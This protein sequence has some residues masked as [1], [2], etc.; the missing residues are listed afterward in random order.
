MARRRACLDQ[1]LPAHRDA[2]RS[3][4]LDQ[5]GDAERAETQAAASA[6]AAVAAWAQTAGFEGGDP[7]TGAMAQHRP[8][9]RRYAVWTRLAAARHQQQFAGPIPP[10]W[11]DYGVPQ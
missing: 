9:P 8:V 5:L 6:L 2:V 7:A 4:L 3:D 11:A 1:G 10:G